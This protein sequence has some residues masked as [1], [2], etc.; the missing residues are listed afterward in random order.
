[1]ARSETYAWPLSTFVPGILTGFDLPDCYRI[2]R[3]KK[4]LRLIDPWDANARPA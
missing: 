1:M 3:T 2:L 4:K